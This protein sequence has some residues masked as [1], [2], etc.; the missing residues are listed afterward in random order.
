MN[1]IGRIFCSN[2]FSFLLGIG[3]G[4]VGLYAV[5]K[6]EEQRNLEKMQREIEAAYRSLEAKRISLSEAELAKGE[7]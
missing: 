4:L 6:V 2:F 3:A 1:Q 7:K 5:H